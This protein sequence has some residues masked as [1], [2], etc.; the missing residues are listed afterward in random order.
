MDTH[1]YPETRHNKA[2]DG[3]TIYNGIQCQTTIYNSIQRYT[4][5]YKSIQRYTMVY[6]GIRKRYVKKL[7]FVYQI[8]QF[9]FGVFY[10]EPNSIPLHR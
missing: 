2:G 1:N 3:A 5:V 7:T 10:T 4:T 9:Y 8:D 6:N